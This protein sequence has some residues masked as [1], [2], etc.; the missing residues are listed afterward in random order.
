MDGFRGDWVTPKHEDYV[1][2]IQRC[3]RNA[4]KR[5][6][7]VACVKDEG[8]VLFAMEYAKRCQL[9]IAVKCELPNC[10]PN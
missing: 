1:E 7:V 10:T 6:S 4:I 8:D 2:L 5:A 9:D 3:A